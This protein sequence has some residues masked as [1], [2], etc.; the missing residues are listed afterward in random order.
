MIKDEEK[1]QQYY[2]G[3]LNCVKANRYNIFAD[4]KTPE[5]K[6]TAIL[7][8]GFWTVKSLSTS[9]AIEA[10]NKGFLNIGICPICGNS[11]IPKKPIDSWKYCWTWHNGP[12]LNLCKTCFNNGIKESEPLNNNI[13]YKLFG[14]FH[15][16]TIFLIFTVIVDFLRMS[17]FWSKLE[18]SWIGIS[19]FYCKLAIYRISS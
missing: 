13:M 15:Y 4:L 17:F 2:F 16:L 6:V 1:L 10:N 19:S 3:I 9:D 14:I 7:T 18:N 11:T 8:S 12:T 5:E